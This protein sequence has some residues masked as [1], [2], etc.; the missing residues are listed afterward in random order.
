MD[1]ITSKIISKLEDD[2]D[3]KIIPFLEG[4]REDGAS[5]KRLKELV[6]L[7]AKLKTRHAYQNK[8]NL[9]PINGLVEGSL[10]EIKRIQ[11]DSKAEL[12]FG[13]FLKRNNIPFKFQYKIGRYRAD[14]L[15]D[16]SLVVELDGPQHNNRKEYDEIRDKYIRKLG[17][18]VLR[19]RLL[20]F[21]LDE[22]AVLEAVQE[23]R[24]TE[25]N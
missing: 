1:S 12:I 19:I 17:Y 24:R 10:G 4:L 23:A 5:D 7:H 6:I 16:D 2:I 14:F 13:N 20:Y 8:D 11:E 25:Q 9:K 21:M 15:I 3:D 18:K 22:R